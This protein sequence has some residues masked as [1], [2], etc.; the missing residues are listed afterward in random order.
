MRRL[1]QAMQDRG[2]ETEYIHCSAD[3]DS[4]DGVKFP[5]LHVAY[6]DGTA[7]HDAAPHGSDC[8]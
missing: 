2:V 6:V 7:P 1:G 4:L 5:A 8:P 3:P